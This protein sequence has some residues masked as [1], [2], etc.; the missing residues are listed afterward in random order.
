MQSTSSVRTYR[1]TKPEE[2]HKD[3]PPRK[4]HSIAWP[5]LP[6]KRVVSIVI[7][8]L[9]ALCLFLFAQ[10]RQAQ[11]KL[12]IAT[13]ANAQKQTNTVV[14]RVSKLIILPKNQTPTVA[15]VLDANKLKNQAFFANSQ[16]GDKVLIY[17]T[18]KQAYLYRPSTNQLVNVSQVAGQ[19]TNASA[20]TQ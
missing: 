2:P 15:T 18:T 5:R 6:L 16:N 4:K 17:Q 10:Y 7:I 8:V 3:K 20:G 11:H 14:S 1:S 9:I 13:P 19:M 12:A